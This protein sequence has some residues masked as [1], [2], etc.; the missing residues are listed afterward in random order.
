MGNAMEIFHRIAT[1]KRYKKTVLPCATF[2][3]LTIASS[4]LTEQNSVPQPPSSTTSSTD[5]TTNV[6]GTDQ[7]QSITEDETVPSNGEPD[8]QQ[9]LSFNYPLKGGIFISAPPPLDS[10]PHDQTHFTQ[11]LL[12]DNG[13]LYESTGLY[14]QSHLVKLSA[15]TGEI[16]KKQSVPRQYF[17]EGLALVDD[18]LIQLSWKAGK[19]FVYHKESFNLNSTIDYSGQG[20][21]IDLKNNKLYFSD[22]SNNIHIKNI[23]DLKTIQKISVKLINK[24]VNNLNEL[25]FIGDYIWANIWQTNQIAVI[26]PNTGVVKHILTFGLPLSEDRHA[27]D[28][29]LNGIAYNDFTGD[30]YITGKLFKKI[31][32]YNINQFI[33]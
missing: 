1:K 11:G 31:Y 12:Y 24:P 6:N 19:A 14:G 29:V 3:L 20:W 26:N 27:G 4:A 9:A 28:N 30:I 23:N 17:A 10:I 8:Q 15:L 16:Q 25:E 2:L 5:I 33:K 7:T 18:K 21:G 22:G 32:K 13:F